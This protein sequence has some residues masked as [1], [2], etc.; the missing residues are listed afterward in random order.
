MRILVGQNFLGEPG[1]DFVAEAPR[2]H[3]DHAENGG[4]LGTSSLA[5]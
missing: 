5:A 4:G 3:G 2:S 1:W